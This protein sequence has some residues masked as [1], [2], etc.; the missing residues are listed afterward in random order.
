MDHRGYRV[1]RVYRTYTIGK[2][3]LNKTVIGLNGALVAVC[4]VVGVGEWW[5]QIAIQLFPKTTSV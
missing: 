2:D 1:Y 4:G 3:M 5:M